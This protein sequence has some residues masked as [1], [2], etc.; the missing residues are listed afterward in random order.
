MKF[1][2]DENQSPLLVEHLRNA[3]HEAV[4]VRDV[5]LRAAEDVEI[6]SYA[7]QHEQVIVSGDTDFG[8][9]LAKNHAAAPSVV[10]FRRQGQRRAAQIADLLLANL[11]LIAG[12]LTAGALVVLDQDRIRIRQLPMR[13]D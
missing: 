1:L 8:E 5:G 6:L 2:L 13:A 3:G 7:A 12:D 10:L 4:H 9:L 11:E